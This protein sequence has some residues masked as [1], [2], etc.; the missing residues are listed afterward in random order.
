MAVP[1]FSDPCARFA[2]L[3]DAYYQLISGTNE[4]LVR[5]RGPEGEREVRFGAGK[6]EALKVEM[7]AA[8]NAC[9]VKNGVA[10]PNRR[11]AIRGG[12]RRPNAVNDFWTAPS[13]WFRP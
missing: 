13:W 7:D 10:D 12:A 2:A 1:D 5:Y 6:I 9:A 11:Y 4:S 8:E 3:R